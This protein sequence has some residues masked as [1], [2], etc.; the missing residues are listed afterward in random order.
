MAK[1]N[2]NLLLYFRRYFLLA[3]VGIVF[4]T[5]TT[6]MF[7]AKQTQPTCA[8]SKSCTSDL[9]LKIENNTTGMFHG[10]TVFPPKIDI[11]LDTS[12]SPVLGTST[13]SG[14]KHIYIDLSTQV[15]YA[16][17]GTTQILKTFISSG[18]W[19]KTPTGNFH[20]WEK[21]RA[22]RM[23][24]GKGADAY[25]LPNVPYVMYYYHDFGTHGAYWHDNFGYPMSHGCINMRQ[26]D[27]KIL[28]DWADGPTGN[29]PGTAVS[30]CDQITESRQCIQN[31]PIQ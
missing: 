11:A 30:V 21:L 24:G 16:Y 28:Y 27:A 17:Q 2:R 7:Q 18:K 29:T 22:T 20:I 25:D 26:V 8:N 3:F 14:E 4:F 12:E 10:Q 15:L 13:A 6:I 9:S 5:G 23:T 19:G 1:K 31:N